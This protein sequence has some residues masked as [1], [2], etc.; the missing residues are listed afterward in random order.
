M[1]TAL[2]ECPHCDGG[3]CY[4][5]PDPD[6]DVRWTCEDCHGSGAIEAKPEPLTAKQVREMFRAKDA[7]AHRIIPSMCEPPDEQRRQAEQR[8]RLDEIASRSGDDIIAKQTPGNVVGDR[9]G[10]EINNKSNPWGWL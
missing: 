1:S 9:P 4:S 3:Y 6:F 5:G 7:A 2:I 8:R 10:V